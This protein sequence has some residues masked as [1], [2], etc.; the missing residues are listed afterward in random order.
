MFQ[1][2]NPNILHS[3]DLERSY[4]RSHFSSE[5]VS[6]FF[7]FRIFVSPSSLDLDT[8]ANDEIF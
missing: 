8:L 1:F 2:G 3:I 7:L 6:S 4:A 5:M